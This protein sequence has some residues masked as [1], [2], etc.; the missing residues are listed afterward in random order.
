M[1]EEA[2]EAGVLGVDGGGS[3]TVCVVADPDGREM[4]RAFGGPSNH[5][6]VG[7]DAARQAIAEAVA[8]ARQAAGN[9]SLAAAC[10][11]MAGLDRAEDEQV[12]Q[13]LLGPLL[14]DTRLLLVHDAEIAL[15]GGTGGRREGVVVIAGTGSIAVGY[16]G[17][18]RMVRAG[19]WGHVLGDEGSGYQIA[20]R[21]L[22]AATRARDGRGPV[23]AL[24]ERL[25]LAAGAASLEDLASRIYLES[26]SAAQIAALAPVVLRAADEGD[27]VAR[28]IVAGSGHE[29]SRA[30]VAV[31]RAL[32]FGDDRLEVVLSGGIFAGSP[33]IFEAVRGEIRAFAPQAD[34]H[35]PRHEPVTGAIL[36]ALREAQGGG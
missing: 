13:G 16:D 29:L 31:I 27:A 22:N 35:L 12:L 2:A 4:A 23:T 36:L 5:Q 14:P 6:S 25:P 3:R 32:G 7:M 20:Q 28:G 10:F 18:G 19:G 33:A 21:G 8:G 26:W 30:A 15:V 17:A 34:I 24:L 11:G 9:P 1:T